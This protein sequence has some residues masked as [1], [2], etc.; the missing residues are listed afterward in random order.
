MYRA[1][2]DDDMQRVIQEVAAPAVVM[3]NWEDRNAACSQDGHTNS[4]TRSEGAPTAVVGAHARTDGDVADDE[5]QLHDCNLRRLG[6]NA[7][8]PTAPST[9]A[10]VQMQYDQQVASC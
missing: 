9:V 6:M 7:S 3:G 10:S 4:D 1:G 2:T 5:L 8:L